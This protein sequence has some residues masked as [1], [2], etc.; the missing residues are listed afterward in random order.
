M[1][2]VSQLDALWI[3]GLLAG[4]AATSV[5]TRVVHRVQGVTPAQRKARV[6]AANAALLASMGIDP[7]HALSDRRTF[8]GGFVRTRQWSA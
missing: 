4:S 8:A 7:E 1:S 6:Y 2:C 3:N 5:V